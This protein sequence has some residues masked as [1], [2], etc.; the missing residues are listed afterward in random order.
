MSASLKRRSKLLR[1]SLRRPPHPDLTVPAYAYC[2][3]KGGHSRTFMLWVLL[4][5]MQ[6]H[7]LEVIPCRH[8]VAIAAFHMGLSAGHAQQLLRR[9]NGLFWDFWPGEGFL[10]LRRRS[11]VH[12]L[13]RHNR[14]APVVKKSIFAMPWLALRNLTEMRAYMSFPVQSATE[15]APTARA[16]PAKAAGLSLVTVSKYRRVLKRASYIA[17][18]RNFYKR[19]KDANQQLEKGEFRHRRNQRVALRRLADT[20]FLDRGKVFLTEKGDLRITRSNTTVTVKDSSTRTRPLAFPEYRFKRLS[21]PII[22]QFLP[23]RGWN[24]PPVFN[25]KPWKWMRQSIRPVDTQLDADGWDEV[26]TLPPERVYSR[27]RWRYNKVAAFGGSC[28][29]P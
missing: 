2:F 23:T 15:E 29:V 27:R 24:S 20:V 6:L 17:V 13:I 19:W 10:E 18:Q 16:Y 5:N 11:A 12:A 4:L 21:H 9:G 3:I 25:R 7:W 8:I 26:A 1:R 22:F 28:E 14:L